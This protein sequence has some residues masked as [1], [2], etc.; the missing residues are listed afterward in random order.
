MSFS[1]AKWFVGR[2]VANSEAEERKLTVVTGLPAMG[3]DGLGSASYGP[4]AALTI[5]AVTGAAGLSAIAPI[6]WLILAL[7]A[8]LFLS[9]WQT[10]A[11]Y[12]N[13]GGS[14]I[15][16]KDNLGTEAGL[17][18]AAA[19]MVD[20]LL[21]VAVG[22]SAGV[23]ALTSA[24]PALQSYTLWLCLCILAAITVMNLRGTRE[25]G[26]AW[27]THLSICR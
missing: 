13:N 11:A 16:A 27:G 5:L 17:L 15:V 18:A 23:G 26:I 12:P 10:I 22:I 4:E 20:Y 3:L 7:L 6:T 19:L 9:Y 25:S 2:P 1:V 24:V 21:N 8:I 14:Y